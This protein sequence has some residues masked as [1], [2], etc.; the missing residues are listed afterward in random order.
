[1]GFTETFD[2]QMIWHQPC[3]LK[4]P[5]SKNNKFS[6]IIGVSRWHIWITL[7]KTTLDAAFIS[8]VH[9]WSSDDN[10]QKSILSLHC[11]IQ[12]PNSDCQACAARAS[13]YQTMSSTP[14]QYRN[15]R[16][17]NLTLWS[18]HVFLVTSISMIQTFVGK[19]VPN[20]HWN[21]SLSV[22]GFIASFGNESPLPE[23]T[24][25]QFSDIPYR[26]KTWSRKPATYPLVDY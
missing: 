10:L 23:E 21:R 22:L 2:R 26:I 13:S 25:K 9:T 4:P 5:N 6:G 11:G 20:L 19:L 14:I 24:F 16:G 8:T 1:M 18:R 17:K 12:G 7:L 3:T 15:E